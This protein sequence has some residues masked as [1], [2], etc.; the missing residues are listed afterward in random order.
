[1]VSTL[2]ILKRL[3]NHGV[4]FVVVDGMDNYMSRPNWKR[5]DNGI[6]GKQNEIR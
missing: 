5:S 4:E 6:V 1:M 3:R 2:D